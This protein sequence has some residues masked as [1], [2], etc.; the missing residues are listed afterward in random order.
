MKWIV[1]ILIDSF[2]CNWILVWLIRFHLFNTFFVMWI[3]TTV[4]SIYKLLLE[5]YN[6]TNLLC[7]F[8]DFYLIIVFSLL[9][10]FFLHNVLQQVFKQ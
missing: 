9:I 10:V 7:I 8:L 6:I 1:L 5:S 3:M 4:T 2:I